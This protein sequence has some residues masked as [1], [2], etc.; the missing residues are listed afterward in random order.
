[1]RFG[2][3]NSEIRVDIERPTPVG[4]GRSSFRAC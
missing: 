3:P 4:A 2:N 1:V